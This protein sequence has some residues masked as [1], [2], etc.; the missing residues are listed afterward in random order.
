MTVILT[1][2]EA[3]AGGSRVRAQ[4]GQFS[5]LMRP[6]Q[7]I[8]R[9]TDD[10]WTE[11]RRA[12]DAAQ[13]ESLGL[14]ARTKKKQETAAPNTRYLSQLFSP[15]PLLRSELG[16]LAKPLIPPSSHL[17]RSSSASDIRL[18]YFL[19]CLSLSRRGSIT[20]GIFI[21]CSPTSSIRRS[22]PDTRA[23]G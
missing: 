4:P 6:Y 5:N 9:Q 10:R 7:Q 3:D 11:Q 2:W 12:E 19:P 22:V 16:A 21:Y 15:V 8:D 17:S 1:L 18:R 20:A 14:K 13:G 23:A